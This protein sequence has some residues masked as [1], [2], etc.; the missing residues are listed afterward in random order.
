MDTTTNVGGSQPAG[1]ELGQQKPVLEIETAVVR[2]AGDSGDGMQ[3]AG[4]QFTN[5]SAIAGNDVST[6]PDFPAEIRAPTGSL[7]GVS[8]YQICLS[9]RDIYTPGDQL[10]TLVAM[11]PA[12]LK[13]NLQ[14]LKPAGLIVVD[15]DTY[16][17]SELEKAGYET[18]PL[19]D[20]SLKSYKVIRVPITTLTRKAVEDLGLGPAEADRCRNLFAL[21][22][23]CWLYDRPVEPTKRWIDQKFAKRPKVAEANKRAFQAGYNYGIITEAIAV[24]YHV[25]K[26]PIRPGRYRKLTGNEAVAL[27]LV[28]AAKRANKSLV[29]CS[30]P[31]TPASEILHELSGMQRY[32]VYTIQCEDEIAAMGAAIGAAFG[33]AIAATG[34]SGPGL[35]LKLEAIGLA[36]MLELPVVIVDVQRAGPSTGLPTKP[37]QGDLLQALF[38][39]HGEAPLPVLAASSPADCFFIVQEAVEIAVNYMTPV[40]VLSDGYLALG[41]EPWRIPE[42]A[43]LKPIEVTHPT[44]PSDGSPFL[45]YRRNERLVRPWA[46]PGTPGLEHRIGGLEKEHLTGNVS[47]DPLNHQYMVELRAR[48]IEGVVKSVPDVQVNG[49]AEGELLVVGWGSTYGSIAQAVDEARRQNMDVSFVHLRYLNPLPRNLGDVLQR[50]EKVLV[51]E[52]NLGQLR[53]LL[54]ARYLIDPIG[55]NKVQGRPFLVREVYEKIAELLGAGKAAAKISTAGVAS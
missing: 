14:D 42:Q 9:G 30:Y 32:R 10:D 23:L 26:A 18:N 47:Y 55:L 2:F 31:I 36:V 52:M 4:S 40:I 27:G 43:E 39:R 51:P 17:P 19:D 35:S 11:N 46:L 25:P 44:E 1:E 54:R 53:L 3:L 37:E 45:P 33:G 8:S 38:G 48:K 34:T 7:R 50:F 12:A 6:F 28:T 29:Y 41:A 21:G 5:I 20:G 15:D 13:V 22:L 24:H 16:K 49:P